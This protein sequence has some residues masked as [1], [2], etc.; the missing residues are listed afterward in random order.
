MAKVAPSIEAESYPHSPI[1]YSV[2]SK[3]NLVADT[4]SH[5][6]AAMAGGAMITP[7]AAVA[8]A[9]RTGQPAIVK[10]TKAHRELDGIARRIFRPAACHRPGA[11]QYRRKPPRRFRPGK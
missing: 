7:S 1:G 10:S 4:E 9:N 2:R 3:K 11:T 5:P 8:T 6:A